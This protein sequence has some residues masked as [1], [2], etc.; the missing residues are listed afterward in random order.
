M[1]KMST[2]RLKT[3]MIALVVFGGA[4]LAQATNYSIPA[5]SGTLTYTETT[6]I[7]GTCPIS[8]PPS[9]NQNITQ[10]LFNNFAYNG[11]SL[12][13]SIAYISVP[14]QSS[15]CPPTGWQGPVPLIMETTGT[16]I[17][18]TPSL[19][20][21]GSATTYALLLSA[22]PT[23]SS[24]GTSVQF[25]ATQQIPGATG[26]ITFYDSSTQLGT[27]TL[28]SG[29]ANFN[30]STLAAATHS[31]SASYSGNEPSATSATLSFVV[32]Q[33][34]QTITF[35][36]SSPVTYGV[37]PISLSATGGGSGN[38][39]TFSVQSGPGTLSGNTLTVNHAGSIVIAANQAGNSNYT[40]APQV[41]GTIVVNQAIPTITWSTPSAVP[42]G[43]YLSSVQ[44][45][46][47]ANVGGTFAYSPAAGT[48]VTGGT[49]QLNT[50]FTPTDT[51]DYATT[52]AS[53]Q[54]L[55]HLWPSQGLITTVAGDNTFGF[56][57]NGSPAISG[58]LSTP[59][60]V[61]I[62]SSGNLYISDFYNA[63][64]RKV[65][66]LTGAISDFAGTGTGGYSGDG[67]AA[68]SAQ[69][70]GP[71]GLAFDTHG[72]LYIADAANNVVR[73]VTTAGIISTVAGNGTSGYTGN[74]G[75]AT[76]AE[77]N[78]P[79]SVVLDSSSNIYISDS[80]NNVIR[81]VTASSGTITLYA[82]GGSGCS[83]YPCTAT[84][85]KLYS[86]GIGLDSSGN[87]Y[88][89]DVKSESILKVTTS[90]SLSPVAGNGTAGYSGNGGPAT[91]ASLNYPFDVKVDS[92]GN[93]YVADFGN[94]VIRK[95][96]S[97]GI[98]T[99]AGDANPGYSGDLGEATS[100][101]L[102][103]PSAV[104]LD[105]SSNIY[106]AD[107]GNYLV[108]AVGAGQL[109]PPIAWPLPYP[110]TYGTA[111]SSTQLDATSPVAGTI[112]YSP[113]SGTVLHA[114]QKTITATFTPSDT[115]DY[116]SA[117]YTV[118]LTVDM[119]TPLIGWPTPTSIND[120][121]ALSSTQL[122]ATATSNGSGVAGTFTY[123]PAAG[124]TLKPGTRELA[125]T[126]T[127]SDTSD[128]NS[129]AGTTLID[130]T[131]GST[132]DSGT[133][134][135]YVN[136][137][138]GY[139]P[140]A[141]TT[142]GSSSTPTSVAAGLVSG[143]TGSSVTLT[144]VDSDLTIVANS[145]GSSSDFPFYIETTSWNSG[146]FTNPSFAYPEIQGAL[147]GG[148]SGT[149]GYSKLYEY[150]VG[151]YD[152]ASNL[153]SYSDS[154]GV[155]GTIMGSWSFT[156]DTL[157]R[158]STGVAS[159]G[160]WNGNNVCWVDDAFGNRTTQ[161][162]TTLSCSQNLTPNLSFNSS[163]Q[164]TSAL[165][166]Y[167][168]A[169]NVVTDT[170]NRYL[171]DAE[172]RICA[173]AGTVN[174]VTVMTGYLYDADGIR[175]SKGAITDWSCNPTTSG[176]TTTNDYI[177]GPGGEQLSEY[178]M[179]TSGTMAWL[180]TNVWAAGKLLATY[181]QDSPTPTSVSSG[182]LHFYFDDPL[183]SRRV[184]T[185]FAGNIEQTCP[186]LPYG[187]GEGCGST[188]TENLFTG[189]ER[190][191]ESGNDYF[192]A[193]YYASG[194][195]RF[196]SPDW[197]AKVEPVPYAKLDN[198]QTMN[199]YAYVG[200]NPL[201]R[202]D[203]DGHDYGQMEAQ[204]AECNSN[205]AHFV[206]ESQMQHDFIQAATE[207]N[208]VGDIDWGDDSGPKTNTAY[209]S[210]WLN[211]AGHMTHVGIGINSPSTSGFAT[212]GENSKLT[213]IPGVFVDGEV[214]KDFKTYEATGKDT[215]PH[216]LKIAI[217][218]KAAKAMQDAIDRRF[219]NPGLYSV[220]FRNCAGFVESVLH[221]GH[222]SN[223]PYS[224]V[225]FPPALMLTLN[226]EPH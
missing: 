142:Y 148:S 153:L 73:E 56:T 173:V 27:A 54:L 103:Q 82:G 59:E 151:N 152:A 71:M 187:D 35:S 137:G 104:G 26:T 2:A 52:P 141:T 58:E 48:P 191:A 123:S 53:V 144:A 50:T 168:P 43:T 20:G 34:S 167:D 150:S 6:S 91:S 124:T 16:Y 193:R 116:T 126:F 37:S 200:N 68:T 120:S 162:I 218:A 214:K 21:S 10:Y 46:A 197:S 129:T 176:Y 183:G 17:F 57:G 135:L 216:F 179:S 145:S 106:I 143:K 160:P 177:L 220:Y 1:A 166:E 85:A 131:S 94:N 19:Q 225:F 156:Y 39:V 80:A 217:S 15:Y 67:G 140:V 105:S 159:G 133:V 93:L 86:E 113:A 115:V 206:G 87:L 119:A 76:S 114:G 60:G 32:S 97:Y 102:T 99:S 18:F 3:R 61:A 111:L 83:S 5:G 199:L 13:G 65:T 23:S 188:P 181:S 11:T 36:P 147:E 33:A 157:N 51:T 69:L 78:F 202:A 95:V 64:V 88:I 14:T 161:A 28:S 203:A 92:G 12:S 7:T 74:G 209:I 221:A 44:L 55:V 100:A 98:I 79:Q 81:K 31:I 165:Y 207:K 45:N 134:A 125:V 127:P 215:N 208:G 130:V 169:G 189:K 170:Q 155:S 30:I 40:A 222:V 212:A 136:S 110:I 178:T 24:Y 4:Q 223:V 149:S 146:S 66:A 25:T 184:Q 49:Q 89:A 172:G 22:S 47:T 117:T 62:D 132:W 198:P 226:L 219:K 164:I 72:N 154:T 194:I 205:S 41:T 128:Y 101:Q 158:L 196:L 174:G 8:Q 190:D 163:N 204:Y 138:S 108:R 139:T 182:L 186:N 201:T 192:D 171:Y 9:S 180:H 38:S 75:A 213:L 29:V 107:S 90:G 109:T 96:S 211:A 122:D 70:S 195:G 63:V 42:N 77:L 175:V 121:T 210:W 84:S 224:E 118:P 112:A 185:D